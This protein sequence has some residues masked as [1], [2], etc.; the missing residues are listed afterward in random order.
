MDLYGS[1]MC[2]R[3]APSI[4][5]TSTFGMDSGCCTNGPIHS[6]QSDLLV[7]CIIPFDDNGGSQAWFSWVKKISIWLSRTGE[8]L[9]IIW[10]MEISKVVFDFFAD[11]EV[12][13]KGKLFLRIVSLNVVAL[14]LIRSTRNCWYWS[15][16]MSYADPTASNTLSD[17]ICLVSSEYRSV[18]ASANGLP[19]S[20]ITSVTFLT[21]D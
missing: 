2:T 17:I 14:L 3:A 16:S 19:R 4:I 20:F 7:W 6:N 12:S 1:S 15:F 11:T 9:D 8:E 21:W 10:K 18:L 13:S 5:L